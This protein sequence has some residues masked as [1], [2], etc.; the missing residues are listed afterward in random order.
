M[1]SK[2]LY[3]K[4]RLLFIK[5]HLELVNPFLPITLTP[6]EIEVLAGFMSI[7]GEIG[8]IDRFG[9]SSRKIVRK[10]LALSHGGLGNYISALKAKGFIRI[11]QEEELYIPEILTPEKNEQE[12]SF[13]LRLENNG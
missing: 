12:Y 4:D 2:T 1:I 7:D 11:G 8:K 10:R 6:K 9:P 13:R 5:K 3:F